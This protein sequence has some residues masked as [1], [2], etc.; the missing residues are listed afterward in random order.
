MEIKSRYDKE[1]S[2]NNSKLKFV[3]EYIS[4]TITN[5]ILTCPTGY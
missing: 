2:D 4:F 3:I 1:R 5:N